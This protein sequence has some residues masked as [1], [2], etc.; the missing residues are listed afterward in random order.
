MKEDSETDKVDSERR[1]KILR[2]ENESL[3]KE[4]RRAQKNKA[5]SRKV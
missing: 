2:S 1:E 4:D 3:V 5:R